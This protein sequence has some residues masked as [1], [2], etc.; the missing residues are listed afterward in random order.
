MPKRKSQT[1]GLPYKLMRE[2]GTLEAWSILTK[3][4]KLYSQKESSEKVLEYL[5][6]QRSR[7]RSL[8]AFDHKPLV[9]LLNHLPESNS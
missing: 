7:R 8:L 2:V 3:E 6:S 9:S 4:C 5:S 1:K